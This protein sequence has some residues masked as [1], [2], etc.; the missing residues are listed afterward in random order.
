M[1]VEELEELL[2]EYLRNLDPNLYLSDNYV[3][4]DFETTILEKG[5]PY[6]AENKIV[7]SSYKCGVGHESYT[8]DPVFVV[9]N[10]FQQ[11]DLLA[12]I[13]SAD[14]WIAHNTKFEYGWLERCGL[15]LHAKLAF[16]TQIAEYVLRSNRKGGLALDD[17]LKRRG[18]DSKEHLG[19]SLLK[20]GVCPSQ[21]PMGWLE[22]YS[23]K[24][25]DAG[26]QLFLHQREHLKRNKQLKTV[27]TRNLL[28]PVLVDIEKVGMHIDE[29]RVR[30]LHRDYTV[31]K[32][33]LQG[34]I[35]LITDGANPR[36]VP[37]M[38]EVLYD[39]LKFKRPTDKKWLTPGGEP[40]TS[41]DYINTLKPKTKKQIKFKELKQEYSK[42]DAALTKCLNKFYDCVS[43]TTD[44]IITASLN[45]T[46]TATQRLSSTGRNYK[47]QFQ[48]FPRIFKP[49]FK[50]RREGWFIGEIDQAQLEYRG[51]VWFGQD[52]AG[53]YDILHRVDSHGFTAEHIFGERFTNPTSEAVKKALRTE[54]KAHTFKP[55]YGGKSG[56]PD[57]VRY[58]EAFVKK[59]AG[60][61]AIQEEWKKDALN[62]KKVV[63]PNGAIFYFPD[64]RITN[65]GYIT[66]ST[67]ICNYP[68]QSFATADI[69]PI[70]VVYQWHLIRVADLR[71]F[72]V[73]TVHDSA[74][75]EV[76]PDEVEIYEAIGEYAH[77]DLVY[78]YLKEVYDVD[79]NVPLEV[80][81]EFSTNWADTEYW[82]IK[83]LYK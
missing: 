33:E 45:Q 47:A 58:Y 76:H 51:A 53:L 69:V 83:Y 61:A 62:H 79:F 5:S 26:E 42:V 39:K 24:D 60:I 17:C 28:T 8:G 9:G 32:E 82:R 74:I 57:E 56:T 43:E 67:N 18:M 25:S 59:H 40:T 31:R 16:C 77:V 68:V 52:E 23:I 72:L 19:K 65:S 48:N 78:K 49:L 14:Y 75:G 13:E 50:A 55:L 44:H 73:N 4:V 64:T 37:Q 21:W 22:P 12:A 29:E 6:N 11:S 30:K 71:S 15:A 20:A 63:C 46:V 3:V 7:C 34:Q 66:N 54:A 10:E 36:S 70:G 1:K 38:R 80:E 2:P 41:F 27:F 35:D 81:A